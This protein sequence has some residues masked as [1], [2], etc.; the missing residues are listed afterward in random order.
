MSETAFPA[1]S[2]S[3][4][5][6]RICGAGGDLPS[7]CCYLCLLLLPHLQTY[8]LHVDSLQASQVLH[9]SSAATC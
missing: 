9:D 2:C 8:D 3:K 1:K 4:C 6:L 7:C 5:D